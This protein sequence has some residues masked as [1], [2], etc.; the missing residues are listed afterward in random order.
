MLYF[1]IVFFF[2][3]Y[4]FFISERNKSFCLTVF[5]LQHVFKVNFII[6][7]TVHLNFNNSLMTR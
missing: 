6:F 1:N 2:F 5:I 7:D 3:F 4:F